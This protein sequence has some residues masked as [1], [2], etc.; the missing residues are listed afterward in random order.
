MKNIQLIIGVA[1]VAFTLVTAVVTSADTD[2]DKARRL[3]LME[4][5]WGFDPFSFAT[6]GQGQS[7]STGQEPAV[8]APGTG[9]V[10]AASSGAQA[11]SARP[12]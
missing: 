7:S 10:Y 9:K 12:A 2:A 11:L 6:F 4:E 3:A 1:V 8:T 5:A